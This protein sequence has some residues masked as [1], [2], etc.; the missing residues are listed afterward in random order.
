MRLFQAA[1]VVELTSLSVSQLRD[2]SIPR[3]RKL[4]PTDVH[5][6][7]PGQHALYSWQTVLVP[8]LLREFRTDFGVE[9]AARAPGLVDLQQNLQEMSFPCL[10]ATFLTFRGNNIRVVLSAETTELPTGEV[11]LLDPHLLPIATK[12]SLPPPEQLFLFSLHAVA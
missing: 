5:S 10:W 1:D 9:I 8:P 3:Y 11:R 7:G 6:D 2:W 12:R 4:I